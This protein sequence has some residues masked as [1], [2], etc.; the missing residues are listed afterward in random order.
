MIEILAALAVANLAGRLRP[1]VDGPET[2]RGQ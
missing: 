2:T 1:R